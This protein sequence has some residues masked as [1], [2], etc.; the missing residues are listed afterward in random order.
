M[1]MSHRINLKE[2]FEHRDLSY[3]LIRG[4]SAKGLM[5]LA[6]D[7]QFQDI[8]EELRL[9]VYE[10]ND[11]QEMII[12]LFKGEAG[13]DGSEYPQANGNFLLRAEGP[14]VEVMGVL[15]SSELGDPRNVKYQMNTP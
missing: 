3:E 6:K 12:G 4:M 1:N 9:Y 13:F 5:K 10:G 15:E 2:V 8:F 7:K 11:P 14:F